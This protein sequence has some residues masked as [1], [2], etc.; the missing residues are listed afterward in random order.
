MMPN[1][2]RWWTQLV[3]RPTRAPTDVVRR[4]KERWNLMSGQ[5][6]GDAIS[7]QTNENGREILGVPRRNA[8]KRC[9]KVHCLVH[10]AVEMNGTGIRRQ[11][12]SGYF[13]QR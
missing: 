7:R 11:P 10:A 3:C 1:R 13:E 8:S 2:R 4:A 12:A 5:H 9:T 6:D